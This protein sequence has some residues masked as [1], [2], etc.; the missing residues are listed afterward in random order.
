MHVFRKYV[1]DEMDKPTEERLLDDIELFFKALFIRPEFTPNDTCNDGESLLHL[2]CKTPRATAVLK[3]LLERDDVDVNLVDKFDCTPLDIC[4]L[5]KNEE[6]RQLLLGKGGK[7][8]QDVAKI[9]KEKKESTPPYASLEEYREMK[10][11]NFYPKTSN[12]KRL[13]D[14][15]VL[16]KKWI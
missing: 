14:P 12:L 1:F 16:D 6:A 8:S 10:V 13:L 4:T 3:A 7:T 5:Y 11:N 9:D 15:N 2:L